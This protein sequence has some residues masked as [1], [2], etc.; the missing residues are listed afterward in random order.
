MSDIIDNVET[1]TSP[2]VSTAALQTLAELTDD[3]S[4]ITLSAVQVTA[5]EPEMPEVKTNAFKPS[6]KSLQEA[7]CFSH[8]SSNNLMYD[9]QRVCRFFTTVRGCRNGDLCNYKHVKL[10]CAYFQKARQSCLYSESECPFSHSVDAVVI[11]PDLH[12]CP[13]CE[14]NDCFGSVCLRC[15]NRQTRQRRVQA[16]ALHSK[17]LP[18]ASIL[19]SSPPLSPTSFSQQR[20]PYG[21]YVRGP[22]QVFDSRNT[23]WMVQQQ[24]QQQVP[25]A[26]V[27]P[28]WMYKFGSSG[29]QQ[30]QQQQ[31]HP[32]FH[33][34][35]QGP[36]S[37]FPPASSASSAWYPAAYSNP[38]RYM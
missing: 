36:R 9:G 32:P 27:G 14:V 26:H 13:K 33:P 29:Q 30:Q 4:T 18:F 35:Q 16:N 23:G 8:D 11:S 38:A 34:M 7:K 1:E 37:S 28:A 25:L 20:R 17:H 19:G 3:L 22:S 15:N 31:Q 12:L 6:D 5:S 21:G 10:G 2:M 24:Q